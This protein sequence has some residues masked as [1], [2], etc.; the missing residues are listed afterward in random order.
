MTASLAIEHDF[1]QLDKEYNSVRT[2]V[3]NMAKGTNTAIHRGYH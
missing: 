3:K 1:D 2:F